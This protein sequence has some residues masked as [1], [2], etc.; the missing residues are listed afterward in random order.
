M[1]RLDR[2]T[3]NRRERRHGVTDDT[4]RA[5]AW[6]RAHPQ[7]VEQIADALDPLGRDWIAELR[8][9]IPTDVRSR[10]TARPTGRRV[11]A[12]RSR[13]RTRSSVSRGDPDEPG[14]GEPAAD[15]HL[16]RGFTIGAE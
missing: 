4:S 6:V 10:R 5:V 13:R 9:L 14:P 3:Q 11:R 15:H 1:D 7:R 12:R 2:S 8:V 16:A